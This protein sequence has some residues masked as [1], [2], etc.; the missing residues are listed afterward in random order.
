MLLTLKIKKVSISAASPLEV[1]RR[2]SRYGDPSCTVKLN[3]GEIRQSAAELSGFNHFQYTW[4][5][6]NYWK[7]FFK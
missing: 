6:W 4:I 5:Q 1:A 7:L 2:A 3:V